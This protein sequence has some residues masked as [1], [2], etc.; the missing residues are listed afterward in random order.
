[1]NLIAALLLWL[2]M[3]VLIVA[4]NA[5]GDTVIAGAGGPL[6]AELYEAL[7]PLPYIALCAWTCCRRTQQHDA[8][9]L[10]GIGLLWAVSTVMADVLLAHL[11]LGH[12]WRLALVHYTFW[13]GYWF[14]VVPLAQLLAPL[15]AGKL[16][17]PARPSDS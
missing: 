17:P 14:A 6:M 11:L 2:S 7:V 10:L 8:G 9:G 16:R 15:L 12:S 1:M 3:T 4:N 5:I 13:N